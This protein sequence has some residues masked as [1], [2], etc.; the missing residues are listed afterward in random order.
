MKAE[1]RSQG[2][3][4]AGHRYLGAEWRPVSQHVAGT[5]VWAWPGHRRGLPIWLVATAM[6]RQCPVRLGT[7]QPRCTRCRARHPGMVQSRRGGCHRPWQSGQPR[8]PCS[9]AMGVGQVD[10]WELADNRDL[11]PPD[12]GGAGLLR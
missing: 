7:Y 6:S 1:R 2:G 3:G 10:I 9:D 5:R 12:A 11:A 4:I 8:R